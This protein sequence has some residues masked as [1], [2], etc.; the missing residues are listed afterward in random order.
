VLILALWSLFF[1][2]ALAL[3]VGARVSAGLRLARHIRRDT[4]ER[5][6]AKAG[7]ERAVMEV[8]VNATNWNGV[9]DEDLA[10]DE[11][12]FHDNDSLEGGTFS[13]TYSYA[14][15][16]GGLSVTNYGVVS[17]ARRVNINDPRQAR[18]LSA[19]LQ[20]LGV[21][22]PAGLASRIVRRS[23]RREESASGSGRGGNG[24]GKYESLHELLHVEGLT[25]ELFVE[26]EPHVTIFG[27]SCYRGVS[28]GR[29]HSSRGRRIGFVFN[30]KTAKL[31][32]WHE[33]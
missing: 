1:L 18:R 20:T 14:A 3:A 30:G 16:N 24:D 13:V 29:T 2:G 33:E 23:G 4:V 21:K 7:V 26:L 8:L 10:S 19:L 25:R 12:L 32:Y 22:D 17:E 9:R 5:A 28:E 31:L 27:P 11:A 6:L 15:T